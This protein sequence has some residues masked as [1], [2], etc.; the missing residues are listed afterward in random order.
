MRQ[1]KAAGPAPKDVDDELWTRFRAAQDTFFGARDADQRRARRGVRRQRRGQGARSSSRPRRCCP[2]TDLDAAKRALPR[3]RRPLGRRRQG[4]PR[5][6]QGA[7]GPDA[8]RRAGHPRRRGRAVAPAPTPRSPPAPTTW[9]PSSRPPSPRSRPTSPRP[10]PPATTRRSGE[11]EENLASRQAFL[12]MAKR[13][14][15][16]DRLPLTSIGPVRTFLS[17]IARRNIGESRVPTG[18]RFEPD[19]GPATQTLPQLEEDDA[20]GRRRA[21]P[22]AHRAGERLAASIMLSAA[23]A[24]TP[25][26]VQIPSGHP[27]PPTLAQRQGQQGAKDTTCPLTTTAYHPSAVRRRRSAAPRSAPPASV[28]IATVR[29]S[30]GSLADDV[31]LRSAAMGFDQDHLD[32][33]PARRRSGADRHTVGT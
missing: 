17:L 29:S 19:R 3:P 28:R 2:V 4:P 8:R 31:L 21:R 26:K 24:P 33:H 32:Q 25:T 18:Y 16:R 5:A 15:S 7:R 9:S 12:D 27:R 1:W 20:G 23:A 22:C 6:D 11:L 10:A 30:P 14:S 13:R